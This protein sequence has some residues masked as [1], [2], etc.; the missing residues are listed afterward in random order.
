VTDPDHLWSG[1]WRDRRRDEAPAR[2]PAGLRTPDPYRDPAAAQHP[3]PEQGPARPR[4]VWKPAL[5]GGVVSAVLVS[6]VLLGS[7]LAGGGDTT[8]VRELP[9]AK[10]GAAA[11]PP[12]AGSIGAIYA[13]ASRGVVSIQTGSGS[14]T[15]FVIDT[16]GTIVTNSHVVGSAQ[17]V[18]VRFGDSGR[19]LPADVRG[20]DPSN[21]VAVLH[22]DPAST[23]RLYPLQF[24]DSDQVKVGDSAIAIG[25]PLGLD[26]TATAG[27]VSGLGRTITAPN[28]FQID[29]V[30][31]TDAPINP[32]NSGG[33]LLDSK[34]RV[35]GVNSQI[36]TSGGGSGNIGIGFAVPANQVRKVVPQIRN[37]GTIRRAYMGVSTGPAPSGGAEVGDVVSGG[38]ADAAGLQVGDIVT[39]V[40]GRRISVPDDIAQAIAGRSP[41]QTVTVRVERGG[42][43][44]DIRVTLGVRPATMTGP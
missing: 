9:A 25:N 20:S 26:R 14:G 37:G 7:G 30:I 13:A 1:N 22:V 34:G 32:G 8:T 17:S 19:A 6:A 39:E 23:G 21:D 18:R 42:G 35:I 33:P 12:A 44:Q 15:G 16:D 2:P 36:A 40:D 4:S 10:G 38:P 3:A 41:G 43:D 31:Q 27:I 28:G 11:S 5:A 29:E 24:A